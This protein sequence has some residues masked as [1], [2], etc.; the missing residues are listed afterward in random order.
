MSLLSF[1]DSLCLLIELVRS[2]NEIFIFYQIT[3][4]FYVKNDLNCKLIEYF[5]ESF[6]LI[7]TWL[8]CAFSIERCIAINSPLL[9]RKF[10]N[11]K[12]TRLICFCIFVSA[13]TIQIINLVIIKTNC[14]NNS[15]KCQCQCYASADNKL[16]LKFHSYFH[17]LTCMVIIP[18]IIVM[19]CNSIVFY[20][21]LKRRHMIKTGKFHQFKINKPK[22]EV[23]KC[24]TLQLPAELSISSRNL[25]RLN[26]IHKYDAESMNSAFLTNEEEFQS[27]STCN[28]TNNNEDNLDALNL[29]KKKMKIIHKKA[30]RNR[31]IK[32]SLLMIFSASFIV[33]VLPETILN[34]YKSSFSEDLSQQEN[35]PTY[36]L[37][38]FFL[39]KITHY[40]SNYLAYLTLITF[41]KIK[42]KK[43][44]F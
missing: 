40:S 13:L 9:L 18:S 34:I 43:N 38:I 7:S 2:F 26:D 29:K 36:L 32:L 11:L 6:H 30:K 37:D 27:I 39:L 25:T 42:I 1:S 3:L 31:D 5:I 19:T 16:L 33:F 20:R 8:V 22:I 4:Y 24:N 14:I 12:K 35:R 44:I 23:S 17:H 21:I 15:T 28:N 10:F 41:G